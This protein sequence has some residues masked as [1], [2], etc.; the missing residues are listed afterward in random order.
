MKIWRVYKMPKS[1]K[2]YLTKK[3][4]NQLDIQLSIDDILYEKY[5]RVMES[6]R[7]A[8]MRLSKKGNVIRVIRLKDGGQYIEQISKIEVTPEGQV[9]YIY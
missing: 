2:I 1:K 8:E 3:R 4:L 7:R 9:V 6:I 5:K